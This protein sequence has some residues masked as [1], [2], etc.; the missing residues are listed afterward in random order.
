MFLRVGTPQQ[1]LFQDHDP[2]VET[3]VAPWAKSNPVVGPD[4][5]PI[6]AGEHFEDYKAY[7]LRRRQYFDQFYRTPTLAPKEYGA[8]ARW[9]AQNLVR[10]VY[11]IY[12]RVKRDA[13][14][15]VGDIVP[16]FA[17]GP[18]GSPGLLRQVLLETCRLGAPEEPGEYASLVAQDAAY[19]KVAGGAS[20][21]KNVGGGNAED[22]QD[23]GS[24]SALMQMMSRGFGRQDRSQT[25]QEGVLLSSEVKVVDPLKSRAENLRRLRVTR[26]VR[27]L[28][29]YMRNWDPDDGDLEDLTASL[30]KL[31]TLDIRAIQAL[32]FRPPDAEEVVTARRR[33][34]MRRIHPAAGFTYPPPRPDQVLALNLGRKREREALFES[35]AEDVWRI[36]ESLVK[37][38]YEDSCRA[39]V[40]AVFDEVQTLTRDSLRLLKR[41]QNAFDQAELA[42]HQVLDLLGLRVP[43][44]GIERAASGK[45]TA[46][47][48]SGVLDSITGRASASPNNNRNF[49]GNYLF[50]DA[51]ASAHGKPGSPPTAAGSSGR[52]ST[53]SPSVPPADMDIEYSTEAV[54]PYSDTATEQRAHDDPYGLDARYWYPLDPMNLEQTQSAERVRL[55]RLRYDQEK[56]VLEG[57]NKTSQLKEPGVGE[58]DPDSFAAGADGSEG[59]STAD[60]P[61]PPP[62]DRTPTMM[63]VA[64]NNPDSSS[65]LPD[66]APVTLPV[67]PSAI[68]VITA[69]YGPGKTPGVVRP[70]AIRRGN[71]EE[72]LK[73]AGAA[74]NGATQW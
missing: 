38:P 2:V 22:Q 9:A 73:E 64:E 32:R 17:T 62:V 29:R 14:F 11:D 50:P 23:T 52:V 37:R 19:S 31:D 47:A 27:L 39:P 30:R 58:E 35:R 67:G 66:E 34:A 21:R 33:A 55:A 4:L 72:L 18:D 60:K 46:S 63:G 57:K 8:R 1:I 53:V 25:G 16:Q 36:T 40:L 42:R 71:V 69:S 44:T 70:E 28:Q 15:L 59:V 61:V 49:P 10:G 6:R 24:G 51:L 5:I 7:D 43:A 26:S 68:P 48:T 3:R 65:L 20:T 45:G 41:V 54:D 12:T 56:E 74:D 13:E